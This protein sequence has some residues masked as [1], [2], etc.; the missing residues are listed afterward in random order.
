MKVDNQRSP[1][2][3]LIAACLALGMVT[4]SASAFSTDFATVE[5]LSDSVVWQVKAAPRAQ[6]FELRVVHTPANEAAD[7]WLEEH[8]FSRGASI[9]YPVSGALEDGSYTW[10]LR[11]VKRQAANLDLAPAAGH[12]GAIDNNGRPVGA[13]G[14]AGD[15][16]ER[17]TL[18]NKG[19]TAVQSGGFIVV[20]GSIPDMSTGEKE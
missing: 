16:G 4:A 8:S 13:G 9:Y 20:G 19:R 14:P 15:R 6:A 12:T 11:A 3:R 10:E 1:K 7:S 17:Q 5:Y 2:N 18:P